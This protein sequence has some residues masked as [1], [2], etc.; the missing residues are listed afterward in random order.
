MCDP[1]TQRL[2]SAQMLRQE[3]ASLILSETGGLRVGTFRFKF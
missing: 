1:N 2:C 3:T